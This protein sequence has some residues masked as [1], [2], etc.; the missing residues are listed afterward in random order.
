M[1]RAS[2]ATHGTSRAL[3]DKYMSRLH[4]K[5]NTGRKR[6][7][8]YSLLFIF[9]AVGAAYSLMHRQIGPS[10]TLQASPTQAFAADLH[11]VETHIGAR[12][13]LLYFGGFE[14][15][16]WTRTMHA[17]ISTGNDN[18][19]IL[20]GAGYARSKALR[21]Q[22]EQ[23]SYG[24]PRSPV[25]M[26]A[27][28][29][30][31]PFGARGANIGLH[32]D[33]YFR[34][35]V[36]FQQGFAFAKSGKLPGLAGGTDNSG[37]KPPNGYDGWSG[38]LNWTQNGGIISYMYIPGIRKYGLELGWAV[39][40]NTSLIK[41]GQWSCLEMHYEMNT[42]GRNDGVAQGWFNGDLALHRSDLNF[43][44][45]NKL[46]IDNILFSTFFGGGTPDYASPR[47]QHADFDDFVVSTHY[48]GCP[49]ARR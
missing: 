3:T 45:T 15:S 19:T 17:V 35:L 37:G 1:T 25:G 6:I 13:G 12:N 32:D 42:P 36:K 11:S 27:T 33:L 34:Y 44:S 31:V 8:A 18:Y 16:P 49:S 48:I 9:V 10:A 24:D 29:F 39:D 23:G 2:F 4:R 20:P 21:A 41:P 14:D 38:R 30:Q 40:G 26:S 46:L 28:I 43:R 5:S 47:S 22:Y 7:S